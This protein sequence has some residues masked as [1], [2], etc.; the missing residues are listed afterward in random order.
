MVPIKSFLSKKENSDLK[1]NIAINRLIE[2]HGLPEGWGDLIKGI[3]LKDK[4]KIVTGF[5]G[6]YDKKPLNFTK[7]CLKL[8]LNVLFAN[9]RMGQLTSTDKLYEIL[10]SLVISIAL[11][12]PKTGHFIKFRLLDIKF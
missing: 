10:S 6:I 9:D 1:I 5:T 2:D 11:D 3:L 12:E 4:E 8:L 7:G